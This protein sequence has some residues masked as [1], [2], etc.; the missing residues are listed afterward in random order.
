MTPIPE[1]P[2][3]G[4][5]A[6]A[7]ETP[8]KPPLTLEEVLKRNA[9]LEHSHKNAREQADRQAK[10]LEKYQKQERDAEAAKKAED[11]A[12]LDELTRERKQRAELQATHDTYTKSMQARIIRYEVEREAAKLGIIDPEAAAMLL[13]WTA[14]ETDE[15]GTP[16]NAVK[17]LEQLVKNKPYLAPKVAEQSEP[18]PPARGNGAPT[19]PAMNPG[20]SNIPAP[21]IVPPGQVPSF[22]EAYR[23]TREQQKRP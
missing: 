21:G 22:Q 17:L 1:T 19:I 7:S 16:T 2:V 4:T 14:L 11:D 8:Q 5:P 15:Q 6:T 23:M 13:D 20:R 18:A 3:T 12:K 10:L 9:E